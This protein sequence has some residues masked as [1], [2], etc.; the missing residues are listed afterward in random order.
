MQKTAICKRWRVPMSGRFSYQPTDVCRRNDRVSLTHNATRRQF[1]QMLRIMK[2][3]SFLLLAV[4]LHVSG[5]ALSQNIT[6]SGN[7]VPLEKVFSVIKQQAGYVVMY[8]KQLIRDKQPVSISAKDMPLGEFL[9]RVLRGQSL[10]YRISVETIFLS[11]K[12]AGPQAPVQDVKVSGIVYTQERQPLP[13]ASIRVK[14]T[15]TGASTSAEGMFS[16]AAVPENAVLQ[17]SSIGFQMKEVPLARLTSGG[18]VPDVKRLPG[19]ASSV[20]FEV[21][22]TMMVDSLEAITVNNYATGYQTLSKE[23]A[24][25][26]FATV[27]A[28]SLKQ[29]RLSDLGSLL[30]GRVAGYN[31]G[32]IRGTTSMNGITQPLYVIDGFPVE[33]STF[34]GGSVIDNLPGL[35]LEDIEKI[36]VL[37]D[38]AAASIYGARAA[39]GVV[40]IVT[41]KAKK[42]RPQVNASSTVTYRPFN[43]YTG[44][45]TNSAEIL[46]LEK[47][48]AAVN[49]NFQ[50]AGAATYA[51]SLLKD[52]VYISQGANAFLNFYA[53]NINQQQLDAQ[54]NG[55]AGQGYKYYDDVANYTKRDV[56]FQQYNVNVANASDRNAFYASATYR[57]NALEDKHTAN[58]NL[59]LNIRNTAH[60]TPWLDFEV[61]SYLQYSEGKRQTYSAMA[62]GYAVM[63]YDVLRNADGSPFT[64]GADRRLNEDVLGDIVNNG[65]YSMDITPLDEIGR[66]L[67]NSTGFMSRSYAKLDVKFAK[68]LTYQASFQYE[69]NNLR[70]NT[71]YDKNSYYV[72]N[73]V[74]SFAGLDAN[75]E[76]FYL[77]PYGNIYNRET[78]LVSAY[79]FR[80]QL[81]FDKRFGRHHSVTAIAGWE[82]KNMKLDLNDQTMYNYDPMALSYDLVDAKVLANPLG[83]FFNGSFSYR[84]LMFE[85]EAVKRFVSIYGNVGYAFD[86][87]YL[88][89]G[90]LRWD[91]SN[92][93]GTSSQYQK[94]PLW[95]A[96]LGWNIYRESFFTPGF[97]TFLKLRGSYGVGGNIS[98]QNAPYMTA[99]YSQNNQVGGLQ[100]SISSRPNPLLSWERTF[101]GNVGVDVTMWDNRITGSVDYYRK[102]GKDLLANTMGVPTEGFGYST[103]E[104]NNGEMTNHGLET[105]ISADIVRSK[106]WKWNLAGLFAYNK[107][108]VTYVNVE[109][110]VYFL[111]LDYPTAYPR[112]GN[113]YQAIYG[114]NWAGLSAEGMPQVYDETGKIATFSPSELGAVKYLGTTVPTYSGSFSTSLDYKNFTFAFLLTYEGGHKMRN[115]DLPM[116]RNAYNSNMFSYMTQFGA[117]NRDIVNRWRKPGDEQHTNIPK[118]IFAE[119]PN[120]S[121]DTYTM[122]SNASINVIN[123][124]NI[125]MR[126]ISLAYNLPEHF[127]RQAFLRSARLQ[128]NVE[129]AFLIAADKNAKYLMGGYIKPNYVWSLQLG[130]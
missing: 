54:L 52:R 51:Q 86:D 67:E 2:I 111:Q 9:D 25:G 96:G 100:G 64:M 43:Y 36:T 76:V 50:G 115:T 108:K 79:N 107:N 37:K 126:N 30:E 120:F 121:S 106:N 68:W 16:L 58:K 92:L 118:A 1:Q 28:A 42:G 45:L 110:P 74:N 49:P 12:T 32:L 87:K 91:R 102:N 124:A 103:Y 95:S 34:S 83:T 55:L 66:N 60:L 21:L 13:G 63:P 3:A 27:T 75:D 48:W 73:R 65:L 53:G 80:Q 116:L 31:N 122:Y 98:P 47:E 39:N 71:L 69:N 89:T 40:V 6:F 81:N 129:N 5:N 26:A 56:L 72:R 101:T 112:V 22:L 127:I 128:F 46:E 94:K 99:Y 15:Q 29:Q 77:M 10:N 114:Y 18:T 41:R 93:W 35:N 14:G 23:R 123:A 70:S 90:S 130:L 97:V 88:V 59:G 38:A 17:I 84:D 62:P 33:N 20:N 24:T 78:Q 11:E 61:S 19:D 85:Q 8:N 109:A 113:P 105:T 44:R 7:D 104:I 119:D 57:H 82:T 125:R 4:C 117:V